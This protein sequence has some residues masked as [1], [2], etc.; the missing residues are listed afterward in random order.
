MIDVSEM[1]NGEVKPFASNDKGNTER[2]LTKAE[3]CEELG[4][5][6]STLDRRIASGKIQVRRKP[7]GRRH[8][9]YVVMEKGPAEDR[10]DDSL[11]EFAV[12]VALERILGL[13]E[14]VSELQDQLQKGRDSSSLKFDE[15]NAV[16]VQPSSRHRPHPWWRF[17]DSP[18]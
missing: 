13:E 8:R 15:L 12:V 3:A 7:H 6:L 4:I 10:L 16:M 2:L 18:Q 11:V 17:W 5:S 1:R 9:V 14:K